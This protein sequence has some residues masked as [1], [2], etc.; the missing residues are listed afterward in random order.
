[1]CVCLCSSIS[2]WNLLFPFEWPVNSI[3]IYTIYIYIEPLLVLKRINSKDN[4][5]KLRIATK[6]SH[7]FE[8]TT[9][10][11]QQQ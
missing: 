11:I 1:M 6:A 5:R 9:T 2:H 3:Y 10:T 4:G 8:T 7:E